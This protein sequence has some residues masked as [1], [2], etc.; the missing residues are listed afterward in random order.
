MQTSD[1]TLARH[2][3][4]EQQLRPWDVRDERLLDAIAQI[5]REDYVPAACRK[6]AYAD[7]AIPLGHG[8]AMMPPKLEAR[9]VQALQLGPKDKVLE[10]GTGSGYVTALLAK[11]AGHVH[12]V[13]IIAE[14]AERARIKLAQHGVNN[15][16]VE[17]GD[18]ARGWSKR[19]PYD[20][21]FVTGSMPLLPDTLKQ[22]L[23]VGGR[24]VAIVGRAP[25]M[26]ARRIT[27]LDADYW[28]E[29]SLLETD[30]PALINAPEPAR[31][32]F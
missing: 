10:I 7:M 26:D 8:Q 15:V 4:L 6:L 11:L 1:F 30:V 2:K 14:L 18:A 24:L 32:V 20:A 9:L 12:S 31:F 13:E 23:A 28:S 27:R 21:I 3:M 22:Q 29:E 17:T 16:T 5:P 25:A 19:A